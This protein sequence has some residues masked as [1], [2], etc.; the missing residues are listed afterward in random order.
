VACPRVLDA[1]RASA[2]YDHARECRRC[3]RATDESELC[4]VGTRILLA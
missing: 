3:D 1:I 2:W 4:E